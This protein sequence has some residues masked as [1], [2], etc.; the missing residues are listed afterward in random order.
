MTKLHVVGVAAAAVTI[1]HPVLA[2]TVD[3]AS[4]DAEYGPALWAQ[5]IGTSFGNNTVG[6]RDV[7]GGSEM[8]AVYA[9]INH[10]L[11]Y[12]GIA[13]NLET[14][15]N[16]LDLFFDVAP[17]GQNRLRGDNPDVDFNGLNR[18][19]D[20]GSGNGLTFDA[21]F[22]ADYYLM[23]TNGNIGGPI[24]HFVNAAQILTT[25]G[26]VGAFVGG[27]DKAFHNPISGAGP[28]GHTI[29][30]NNDNSNTLGVNTLGNPFDSDPATVTTGV[31]ICIPLAELGWDG[32]SD[33]R[34]VAFVNGGG[35]DFASN[36]WAGGLPDGFSHLGDPRFINLAFIDGD[37]WVIIPAPSAAALLAL[38]ALAG[39]RRRR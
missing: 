22:E 35:H 33:V 7:A 34:L 10:G 30:V 6:D 19:G 11:L 31:E 17:G 29:L 28:N 2:Q 4:F 1:A 26:G 36:Q 32:V 8:D 24:G 14:N 23:Y 39:A 3:G 5:T 38:G 12:I 13:G 20:D 37:Q 9:I 21:G 16:K 15:F 18:M 25:G 27:G